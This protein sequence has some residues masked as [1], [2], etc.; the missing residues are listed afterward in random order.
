[1]KTEDAVMMHVMRDLAADEHP[2]SVALMLTTDEEIGGANGVGYLVDEVG[3]RC[4]VALVPDGGGEH[5]EDVMI[6]SKGAAHLRITA[7]G[8]STHGSVPWEGEN[9]IEKLIVAYQRIQ[10]LFPE[11]DPK[12]H[13]HTTCNLG[14]IQ[15]GRATNQVPDAASCA[16]DIRHPESTNHAEILKQVQTV[17]PECVVDTLVAVEASATSIEDPFVAQYAQVLKETKGLEVQACRNH[18]AHDGRF[19]THY[20]IPVIVS[21]PRSGGQHTDGEWMDVKSLENFHQLYLAFIRSIR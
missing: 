17:A 1:M 9:A 7:K 19:L 6:A 12:T 20:G 8:V 21:R 15:G 10:A 3:Y 16:I 11:T 18:S 4:K 13:W 14:T 5:E 2:P